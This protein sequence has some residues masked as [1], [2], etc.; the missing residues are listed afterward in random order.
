VRAAQQ[1]ENRALDTLLS[2]VRPALFSHFCRRV[3]EDVADDLAQIALIRIVKALPRIEP[4]RASAFIGTIGKNL[5]RT[6]LRRQARDSER[7][8]PSMTPDEIES[9]ITADA[10][11][12]Q[13]DLIQAVLR[14]SGE[15]LPHELR[16]VVQALLRGESRAQIAAAHGISRITVRT[17]LMRAR[18]ILREELGQT[19]TTIKPWPHRPHGFATPTTDSL[20]RLASSRSKAC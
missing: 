11:V 17:R 18:V 6:S 1:N 10:Q 12:E 3:A 19:L 7:L 20:E 5:L 15:S 14:A 8:S 16:D 4:E 13:E 9:G 2:T